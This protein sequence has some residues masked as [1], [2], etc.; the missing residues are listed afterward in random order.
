MSKSIKLLNSTYWDASGIS[1]NRKLLS[2]TLTDMN[3]KITNNTNNLNNVGKTLYGAHTTYQTKAGQNNYICSL[4]LT[5]GIWVV[6]GWWRY[7]GFELSS[8]TSITNCVVDSALSHYDNE[9]YV[10][11]M[12]S[13][14]CVVS[15]GTTKTVQINL[16]PRNKS[17]QV[18]C[19]LW[20]V[21]IK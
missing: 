1:W 8:W 14:L 9:G 6:F 5:E 7:E 18:M 10:D 16:W 11:T 20:A 21:R 19:R 4:T 2:S 12:L 15:A 17:P 3:T 13:N